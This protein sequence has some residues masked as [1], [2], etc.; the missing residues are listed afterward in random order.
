M[1]VFRSADNPEKV[2]QLDKTRREVDVAYILLS[3]DDKSCGSD[4][5]SGNAN[6]D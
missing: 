1:V 2:D 5:T 3:T 6:L 4:Q